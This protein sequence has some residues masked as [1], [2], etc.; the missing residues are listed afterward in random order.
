M[1]CVHTA[2]V[3]INQDSAGG[4]YTEDNTLKHFIPRTLRT[5]VWAGPDI[6][7]HAVL[8]MGNSC[9]LQQ[10]DLGRLANSQSLYCY[11]YQYTICY[12]VYDNLNSEV[13]VS[14]TVEGSVYKLPNDKALFS[15]I[16]YKNR[17]VY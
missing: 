6:G 2:S 1:T 9:H 5:V 8:T 3:L 15:S 17:S 13:H 11:R 7:Q 12:T 16:Y 10:Q 14:R 4:R